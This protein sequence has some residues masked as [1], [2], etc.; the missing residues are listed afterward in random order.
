MD[1]QAGVSNF[2]GKIENSLRV[3]RLGSTAEFQAVNERIVGR[4]PTLLLSA[5]AARFP[6]TSI[7]AWEA[8]FERL[9]I[10]F[11][12]DKTGKSVFYREL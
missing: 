8:L 1:S 12:D 11:D 7:T 5:E 10:S 2:P 3:T 4:K 6:L 9:G